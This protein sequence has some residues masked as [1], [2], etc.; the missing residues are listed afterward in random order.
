MDEGKYKIMY[1]PEAQIARRKIELASLLLE[2]IGPEAKAFTQR[3]IGFNALYDQYSGRTER[4]RFTNAIETGLTEK[5]AADILYSSV[6]EVEI[7]LRRPPGDMRRAHTIHFRERAMQDLA[8]SRDPKLDARSRLA[9]L[10]SAVYQIRCNWFHGEKNPKH[11]RSRKLLEVGTRI[12]DKVVRA[13][14][15]TARGWD[16]DS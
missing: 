4:Q 11:P 3:W 7:L 10:V 16:T 13:L 15:E 9:H 12:T 5:Q 8:A 2:E 6:E 1:S 14:I